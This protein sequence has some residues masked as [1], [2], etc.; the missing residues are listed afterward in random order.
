MARK[1]RSKR[2]RLSN[3]ETVWVD[4]SDWD[5]VSKHKWYFYKGSG[6]TNYAASSSSGPGFMHRLIMGLKP[7]DGL[8][9]DHIDSDGLN[10][11]RSNLRVVTPA[12]NS[13]YQRKQNNPR[14][15]SQYKGV[16]FKTDK[17]KWRAVMQINRKH[18]HL[19]YFSSQKEAADAYD[20]AATRVW[21]AHS[22]TNKVKRR[23]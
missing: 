3:G 22:I 2:I 11:R 14:K 18:I 4:A 9:V 21:G 17:G 12:L 1:V 10:N 15:T 20:A 16:S 6:S 13:A 7:H 8:M 19:G 23:G 5:L